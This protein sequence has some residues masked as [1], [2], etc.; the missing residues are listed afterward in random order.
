MATSLDFT[1]N[2]GKVRVLISDTDTTNPIFPYVATD[3][4]DVFLD[5]EDDDVF[6]A[7]ALA[8]LAIAANEVLVQKRI[9][10]LDL[11]TD[12][13]AEAKAL[14][15]L[16]KDYRERADA[17]EVTGAFDWA[18]MIDNPWQESEYLYKLGLTG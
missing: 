6:R 15:E 12:G 1:T 16:A 2:N 3:E 9:K 13:P 10:M 4:I 5:L 8:L 18:E 7:A 14:R 11:T 17:L